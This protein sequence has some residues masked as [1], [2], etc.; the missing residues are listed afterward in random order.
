MGH[1]L[2]TLFP[3]YRSFSPL[4]PVWC[5]TPHTSRV[6]HRFFD[7]SPFSPTGRYLALTRLPFEDRLPAPGDT[8]QVIRVDLETGQEEVVAETRAWD[9]Q[10]GAQ[11]QWG[12][13]DTQ[14]FFNDLDTAT[15]Q[16]F[17]VLLDAFSGKSQVL[18]GTV[19]MVSPDGSQVISPCLR[20]TSAVLH[21]YGVL[22][23]P[24]YIPRN[25]GAAADDGIFITDVASGKSHLLISIKQIVERAC[26]ALNPKEF[27]GGDFY[28]LHVKW[29]PQGTRLMFVLNWIPRALEKPIRSQVITM[30]ADGSN[31]RIAIS[32][33]QW[34]KGG[35][36]PNWCPDG[37][38]LIMNLRA[39]NQPPLPSAPGLWKRVHESAVNRF[40]MPSARMRFV[41]VHYDGSGFEVLA[42]R[43][44]GSGHPS[45]HLY[46]RHILTDAYI[47]ERV[48]FGD[49]TVPIRLV[50]ISHGR[51][52]VLI[53]IKTE[54]GFRGLLGELRIDPHPAW[55]REFKRIA[56]NACVDGTRRVYVADLSGV[57]S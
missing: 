3:A 9:T 41:R 24:E 10:L 38:N 55:D 26:P 45:M 23:P 19:Y 1:D 35:H 20:R 49:D 27:E 11:V 13:L 34:D 51:E 56:F 4:V 29:N 37:Q 32:A 52:R 16:P 25:Q 47:D 2:S 42:K 12:T 7:T 48:A 6:I 40:D 5:V 57:L 33:S 14:L 21:G 44:R 54:P 36:H 50:D 39:Y 46:G 28:S 17:G 22:V 43:V 31:V 15:W 53:R 8:A 30:N 18:E